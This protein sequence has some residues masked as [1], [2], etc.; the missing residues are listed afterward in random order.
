MD[1]LTGSARDDLTQLDGRVKLELIVVKW[2]FNPVDIVR[3]C[4]PVTTLM[5]VSGPRT[6]WIADPEPRPTRSLG[7][8]LLGG[9]SG[10]FCRR[11]AT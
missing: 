10:N 11:L 3:L 4:T 2:R 7:D 8:D 6:L 5:N 9:S 1:I